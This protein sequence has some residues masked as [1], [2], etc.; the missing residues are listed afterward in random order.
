MKTLSEYLR[1]IQEN[2][3]FNK[4]R[5]LPKDLVELL[6]K[7]LYPTRYGK[8]KIKNTNDIDKES[9]EI[10]Q[11]LDN[12]KQHSKSN[13]KFYNDMKLYAIYSYWN[14][15]SAFYS[16]RD[17]K[18]YDFNHELG[19]FNEV[20]KGDPKLTKPAPYKQWIQDVLDLKHEDS[21]INY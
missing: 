2:E 9:E 12:D 4:A 8:N 3:E 15:D 17:K 7:H 6:M 20:V 11:W 13:V 1:L 16:F 19:A 21:W 18:I 10:Y 5:L 14:G